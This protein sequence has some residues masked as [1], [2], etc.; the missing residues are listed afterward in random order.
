[1]SRVVLVLIFLI[2]GITPKCCL[3]QPA[4]A[5]GAFGELGDPRAIQVTPALLVAVQGAIRWREAAWTAEECRARARDFTDAGKHWGF[6]PAQLLAIAIDESDL[7]TKVARPDRGALDLGLM[8]VRCRVGADGR[9]SNKPVRGMTPAQVMR[10]GTNIEMG[11][12]ILA[13]LHGGDLASY[14][15]GRAGG[16]RYP[17]KVGA[18]LAALGGVEVR[19]KGQRL[20]TLVRRIVAAVQKERRS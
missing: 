18:I 10:P 9:C 7:R 15:T 2:C 12:R 6:A 5:S 11:A 1:M 4:R 17:Q 19:V 8:A 14:N 20:R 3:A 13:T 16:T